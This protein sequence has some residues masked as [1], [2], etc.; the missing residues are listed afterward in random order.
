MLDKTGRKKF[1]MPILAC[2]MLFLAVMGATGCGEDKVVV[3]TDPVERVIF[4]RQQ[5]YKTMGKEMK[6]IDDEIKLRRPDFER[7]TQ[8][9]EN[10]MATG[11]DLLEWFPEGTGPES[12]FKTDAKS[13]IWEN[14]A[15]F[16]SLHREFILEAE[17]LVAASK[18]KDLTALT[19]Q[20]HAT[21]VS[22]S[23]CHKP[24]RKEK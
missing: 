12:G 20:Y 21:G 19:A 8:A 7:I 14:R 1:V 2:S 17:R 11:T 5:S 13:G 16:E 24:Y 3:P 6:F 9:A 23:N 4:D 15:E 22:C 18:L 10:L